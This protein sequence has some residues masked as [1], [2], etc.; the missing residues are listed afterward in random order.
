M[1][2]WFKFNE[3]IRQ[4]YNNKDTKLW[5]LSITVLNDIE[6]NL[7]FECRERLAYKDD[8]T[9]IKQNIL[10]AKYVNIQVS[11]KKKT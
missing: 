2:A 11:G 4:E 8:L 1:E 9:K 3:T 5:K 6:P 10:K 7:D